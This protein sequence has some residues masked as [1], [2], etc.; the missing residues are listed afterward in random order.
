MFPPIMFFAHISNTS[1]QMQMSSSKML[2]KR[3]FMRTLTLKN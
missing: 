1:F 2:H 3:N